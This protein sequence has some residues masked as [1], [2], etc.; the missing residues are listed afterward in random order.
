MSNV[1]TL[2]RPV[3][4]RRDRELTNNER[5][6]LIRSINNIA[7]DQYYPLSRLLMRLGG[8]VRDYP[9]EEVTLKDLAP[10]G[11]MF[12]ADYPTYG[13]HWVFRLEGHTGPSFGQ[14]VTQLD[15]LSPLQKGVQGLMVSQFAARFCYRFLHELGDTLRVDVIHSDDRG[16]VV[17]GC[18]QS[19]PFAPSGKYQ[20]TPFEMTLTKM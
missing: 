13:L 3:A 7:A 18:I 20:Y 6:L 15:L 17:T 14:P 12:S 11:Y 8:I 2:P 4:P 5:D 1:Y 9:V 10:R 16:V 19:T